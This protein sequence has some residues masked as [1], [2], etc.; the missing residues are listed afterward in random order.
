MKLVYVDDPMCSWCYGFGRP[1]EAPHTDLHEPGFVYDTE[2]A[3]RAVVTVR[4]L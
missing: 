2:P 1:L 3:S 4:S